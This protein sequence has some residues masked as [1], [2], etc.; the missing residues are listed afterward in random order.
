MTLGVGEWLRIDLI[1]TSVMSDYMCM[2]L[3]GAEL[4]CSIIASDSYNSTGL[5]IVIYLYTNLCY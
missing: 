5:T 4:A 1:L 2:Q 3:L